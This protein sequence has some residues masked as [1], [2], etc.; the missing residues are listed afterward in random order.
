L[1]TLFQ[2]D[3]IV[4]AKRPFGGPEHEL[5]YLGAYTHRV[6]ISNHRIVAQSKANATLRW[7]N[8]AHGNKNKL[9]TLQADDFLRRLLL[10]LLPFSHLVGIC[11]ALRILYRSEFAD[12][13]VRL[14]APSVAA[15][16][17]SPG[18]NA[19]TLFFAPAQIAGARSNVLSLLE[20]RLEKQP[21]RNET[22]PNPVVPRS[23][24]AVSY[25]SAG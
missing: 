10:H 14:S 22:S 1:R 15:L 9:M 12:Q 5:R 13:W 2:R 11:K 21:R 25:S 4:Y 19:H 8:S 18:P 17:S 3:W 20:H 7:R 24:V 6:A 23:G 16:A